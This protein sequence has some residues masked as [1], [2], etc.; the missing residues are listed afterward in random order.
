[1]LIT[2]ADG[3]EPVVLS[4]L[5]EA[6]IPFEKYFTFNNS[7]LFADCGPNQSPFAQQFWQLGQS[8]Y[9]IFF[10]ELTKVKP[11]ALTLT[12]EVLEHREQLDAIMIGLLD[13]VKT[14]LNK[15]E[16][17]HQEKRLLDQHAV[18][19]R[20]NRN[21]QQKII[22][23][24]VRHRKLRPGENALNCL[25]CD[26]TCHYP[27]KCVHAGATDRKCIVINSWGACSVCKCPY[28]EHCDT[29]Y[30]YESYTVE[31]EL[32]FEELKKRHDTAKADEGS[33]KRV[34][35]RLNREYHQ[36]HK[37][38]KNLIHCARECFNKL[39]MIALRPNP[40][41]ETDYLD[42]LILNEKQDGSIGYL[43]RIEMLEN[44][45]KKASLFKDLSNRDFDP[46]LKK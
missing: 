12:T 8:S 22:E 39:N 23:D 6:K 10:K 46:L 19:I 28:E 7:A 43:Q 4:S 21:Y 32:T 15:L 11:K 24:R 1:M 36:V 9:G 38:V 2:F 14:G 17:I 37:S 35:D 18:D 42:M 26:K 45:K 30:R 41:T 29:G 5:R 31:R 20:A 40:L 13:D 44:L 33:R 34:L 3:S 25:K 16:R 27:C